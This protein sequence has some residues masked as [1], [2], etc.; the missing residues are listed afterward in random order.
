MDNDHD[1]KLIEALATGSRSL[2]RRCEVLERTPDGD[3]Q[4]YAAKQARLLDLEDVDE[5]TAAWC[6]AKSSRLGM[7]WLGMFCLHLLAARH[8]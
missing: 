6:G 5:R 1:G 4:R 8:A 2:K 3:C 7:A